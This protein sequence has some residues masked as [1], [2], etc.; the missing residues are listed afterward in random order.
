MPSVTVVVLVPQ[1]HPNPHS[2]DAQLPLFQ[3]QCNHSG[4]LPA[5]VGLPYHYHSFRGMG[6]PLDSSRVHTIVLE[7]I[8]ENTRLN[9]VNGALS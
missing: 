3:N 5:K 1:D 4:L 6:Y 8:A 9:I 7:W 2:T